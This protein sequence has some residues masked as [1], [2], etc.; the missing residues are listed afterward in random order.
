MI[1][2]AFFDIDGTLVDFDTH[3]I[4]EKTLETL[5]RL[6]EK[7]ILLCLATGRSPLAL[8]HFQDIEFDLF[9]TFNGSYCFDKNHALFSNS[10][11]H[12]DIL[13]VIR[14]ATAINRPVCVATKDSLPANGTDQD[15]ADYFHFSNLDVNVVS[16][17]DEYLDEDIYQVMLGC[18][19]S[20]YS[21]V[22]KDV[23]DAKIAAWWNR[24]I[25]IIP[26]NGGKGIAIESILKQLHLKKEEAIAFGD[27]MNDVEMLQAV[28]VGVAMGNACEQLKQVANEVCG[29]VGEDGVYYYC[30]KEGLI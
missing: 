9:L 28:G 17:F 8:P 23:K 3:H 21:S 29:S 15:L 14:N 6:H 25:D 5:K 10:I 22:M 27:G 30:L 26:A 19:A 20:E 12:T 7:G 4:S 1:K 16:N 2:I 13:T 11:P 24:A 18:Y